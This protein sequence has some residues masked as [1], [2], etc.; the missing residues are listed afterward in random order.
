L[1]VLVSGSARAEGLS[2]L[3]AAVADND[4][5]QPTIR[6]D[7]RV[8]CI[9]ACTTARA[10]LLG[11]GDAVHVELRDGGRALVRPGVVLIAAEGRAVDAPLDARLGDTTL[12]LR[13]LAVFTPSTLALPQISDDGPTGM[14]VVS[15]PRGP[16]PYSLLVYTLDREKH[17]VVATKYYQDAINNLVKLRRDGGFAQVAGHWRPAE[18]T[19]EDLLTKATT[20]LTLAWRE[21][22]DAPA[23]LFE[24]S[25]LTKPSALSFPPD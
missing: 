12:F 3:L 17:V 25:G 20:R 15:A 9:P 21:A 8:Q 18:I 13:D 22:A 1:A 11:R 23:A 7:V 24:P 19:V 2:G 4:R 16:S 5:F 6:A 14:V 10:I